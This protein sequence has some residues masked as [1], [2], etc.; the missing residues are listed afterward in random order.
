MKKLKEIQTEKFEIQI[1]SVEKTVFNPANFYVYAEGR[2]IF[3]TKQFETYED[4]DKYFNIMLE[5]MR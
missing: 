3:K 1:C 4:A 5:V 2:G